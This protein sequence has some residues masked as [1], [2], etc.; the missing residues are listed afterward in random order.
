M[1]FKHEGEGSVK[2]VEWYFSMKCRMQQESELK[3]EVTWLLAR[4]RVC[5][6]TVILR[7]RV[8]YELIADEAR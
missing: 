2:I 5:Y 7:T 1:Y 3:R 8:V 6:L 4:L